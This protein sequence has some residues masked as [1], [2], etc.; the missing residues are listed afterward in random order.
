MIVLS[1]DRCLVLSCLMFSLFDGCSFQ[2]VTQH[3]ARDI[4]GVALSW[5][6]SFLIIPGGNIGIVPK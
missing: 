6:L 2:S 5:S 1:T 3:E 4:P